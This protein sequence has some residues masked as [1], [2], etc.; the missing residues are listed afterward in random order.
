MI[1]E[2]EVIAANQSP[3]A[4]GQENSPASAEAPEKTSRPM[5]TATKRV[6]FLLLVV[7][8][9]GLGMGYV[10]ANS[11]ES[12]DDA[13]IDGHINSVS[14]RI[15]GTIDKVYVDD[16]QFVQA[17]QLLVDLDP[18]EQT[19]AEQ[20]SGAQYAEA[21]AQMSSAEPNTEMTRTSTVSE[22]TQA[23]SKI[24]DAKAALEAAEHDRQSA[25]SRLAE[26]KATAKRDQLQADRYRQLYEKEETSRQEFESYTA[27]GQA[28]AAKLAATEAGL[29]SAEK[30]VQQRQAQLDAQIAHAS[31]VEKNAPRQLAVRLSAAE[32]QRAS[33]DL[34]RAQRDNAK[35]NLSF[36]QIVSPISGVVTQR[37]AE[38]GNHVSQ[39]EQLLMVVDT[40]HLWVTANFKETQLRTMHPGCRAIV[41]VDAM[42]REFEGSVESLPAIT[43]SR[44]SVLPPE[45]ATG[46]YVK[47]VQRLPVRIRL[48][49]GQSQVAELRPGMSVD[50]KVYLK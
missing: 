15:T 7:A 22:I 34:A 1:T 38:P 21:V 28:S 29:A 47:V 36:T 46:N 23:Q 3:S 24:A 4:R 37:S 18:R 11:Y 6:L 50:A 10:H 2:E 25:A 35:L 26:A 45:N 33:V 19:L 16:N 5:S 42:G 44:S 27:T 30:V 41:K 40:N 48:N 39:G 31:E 49:P 9:V 43:G 17:G 8:A 12:T 20:Q 32:S 14:S 13:Q